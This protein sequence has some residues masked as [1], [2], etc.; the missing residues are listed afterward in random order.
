MRRFG[1]TY[2]RPHWLPTF[3]A[4][5]AD[6]VI[7]PIATVPQSE[8]LTGILAHHL[9]DL[10]GSGLTDATIKAAGIYSEASVPKLAAI[11]DWPKYRPSMG[12]A[13]V[14]PYIDDQGRNGDC[15]VKPDRPRKIK[16]TF[17]KY[18]SPHGKPN[19]P[20]LPLGVA[21]VLPD[22]TRELLMS[23]GEKKSLKSMQSGF[24]CIGLVGVYGF[25]PK[26]KMALLP[27]LERIAWNGRKVF[28]VFDSDIATNA[29][30]QA[31]ES[32][33]GALLKSRGAVVKVV[34]LPEG[35]TGSDG[36]PVKVGLD[37]FLVACESKGLN[38]A[39]ELQK[40]LDAA[41]DPEE[42]DGGTIKQAAS[43]IDAVPEAAAFLA[44]TEM[45]RVPRL[46][47]WRGTWLY[48]RGGA[49]R[50]LPPSE[51]RGRLVDYLDRDF[52]KLSSA[53]V[54][55]VLDGLRAKARLS[56]FTEPPAWLG[57]APPWNP[58][59]VVVCGNGMVHLP[60]LTDGKPDFLLPAT[61]K[62]FTTA[63]LPYDFNSKAPEPSTW[64]KF[65][66]DLWPD[67]AD[68]ISAPA[69]VG[70]V[71]SHPGHSTT[72]NL[73]GHWPAAKWQGYYCPRGAV[74]CRP[75]E[76]LRPY[77]GKSRNK[78]WTVAVAWKI[79]CDR[80]RCAAWRPYRFPNCG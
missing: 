19:E 41:E 31:A 1:I 8:H 62:Y 52:Y 5:C 15:R 75:G 57:D 46:R 25:K 26:G 74:A 48:W 60:T 39:G 63:A 45:D 44:M 72:E 66:A 70:R 50:E 76:C 21:A 42:P 22:A 14:F 37:D 51:V 78:F 77:P 55:N 3:S 18:E 20:Y 65:L 68:S 23:E 64:L 28:I 7:M 73:A 34:R 13:I 9:R 59:D 4:A 69:R 58:V 11:L 38:P 35:N 12:P 67:D 79:S 17:A 53:A 30:V 10:R 43:A 47:Y 29:N 40:L 27:T 54:S 6:Q 56:H 16:G 71:S 61:P 2:K 24:P 80:F 33:L 49:Y 36:K 32:Q